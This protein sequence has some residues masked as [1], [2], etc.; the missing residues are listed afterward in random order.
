MNRRPV[1]YFDLG[2]HEPDVQKVP[3]GKCTLRQAIQFISD[4]QQNPKDWPPERIA[5]EF[6]IKRENVD[7]ILEHF[8]MFEVH[9]PAEKGTTK[10][11]LIDPFGKKTSDFEKLLSDASA[12]EEK[13]SANP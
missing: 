2:Y 10:Q 12:K 11:Y 6:K 7:N 8:R 9:L 5:N 3:R 1:A 13:K 4:N